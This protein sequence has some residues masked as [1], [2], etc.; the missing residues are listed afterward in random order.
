M[1]TLILPLIAGALLAPAACGE[2]QKTPKVDA[3]TEQAQARER[4]RQGPMGAQV[5][6]IDKANALGA[7]INAK[8]AENLDK[9][10]PK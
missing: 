10:D 7:D 9:A 1:R 3:A 5:Q 6:A 2:K 4:A 8:A